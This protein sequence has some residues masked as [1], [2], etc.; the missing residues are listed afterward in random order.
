MVDRH[1]TIR[2]LVD[3]VKIIEWTQEDYEDYIET[4]STEAEEIVR[5]EMADRSIYETRTSRY[6]DY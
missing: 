4:A 6:Y 1:L 2:E 3:S 5:E